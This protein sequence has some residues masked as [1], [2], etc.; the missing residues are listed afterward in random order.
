MY[1]RG[2]RVRGKVEWSV[3]RVKSALR[4]GCVE[5]P[6]SSAAAARRLDWQNA[7]KFEIRRDRISRSGQRPS[8]NLQ[9]SEL[10]AEGSALLPDLKCD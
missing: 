8:G 5:L 1:T 7:R 10:A 9:M 3:G 6:E 4:R 2:E